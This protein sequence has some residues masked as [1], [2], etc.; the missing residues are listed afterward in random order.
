MMYKTTATLNT[1]SQ[2]PA[3]KEFSEMN[4]RLETKRQK[5][6][7][8]YI[9]AKQLPLENEV[10]EFYLVGVCN[11]LQLYRKHQQALLLCLIVLRELPVI[12]IHKCIREKNMLQRL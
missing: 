12:N 5:K 6:K 4:D 3:E 9:Q 10:G 1:S 2:E 8:K 7:K 11:R